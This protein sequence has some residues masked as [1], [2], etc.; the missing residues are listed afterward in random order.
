MAIGFESV[1]K[2]SSTVAR[3]IDS[4]GSDSRGLSFESTCE[5]CYHTNRQAPPGAEDIFH[6][7]PPFPPFL[8]LPPC[9]PI[10][11]AAD[12]LLRRGCHENKLDSGTEFIVAELQH[13][14]SFV[15]F[16]KFTYMC[17]IVENVNRH[18]LTIMIADFLNH[19]NDI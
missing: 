3:K 11:D 6:P 17:G 13:K 9:F 8:S 7:S 1:D 15:N 4:A 14:F 18:C 10:P 2:M 5:H 19:F 16:F 12:L